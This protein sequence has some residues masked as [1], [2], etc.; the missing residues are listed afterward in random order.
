MIVLTRQENTLF[1]IY[2][3]LL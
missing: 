3:N 1:N 2:S